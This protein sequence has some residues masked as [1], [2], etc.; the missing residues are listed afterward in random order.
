MDAIVGMM[1]C[2]GQIWRFTR[3][4][5]V[6]IL[7]SCRYRMSYKKLSKEYCGLLPSHGGHPEPLMKTCS[8]AMYE[9]MYEGLRCRKDKRAS[10]IGKLDIGYQIVSSDCR[11]LR[12]NP[13]A[14]LR[15]LGE[16]CFVPPML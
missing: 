16:R 4:Y 11:Y 2:G 3:N 5:E 6:L 7:K 15:N 9:R 14:H 10:E 1:L 12:F 8:R 13:N